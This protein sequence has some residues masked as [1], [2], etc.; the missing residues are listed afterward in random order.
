MDETIELIQVEGKCNWIRQNQPEIWEA[1]HKYLQISGFLN[2][3][4]TAVF[5]D[6]TA[7]Q[8]GH[9]PFNYKK[10]RWAKKLELPSLIFPIEAE[11]LPDIVEP[12]EQLGK[13]TADAAAATGLAEDIPVIACGVT[14]SPGS[15]LYAIFNPM[16]NVP[17]PAEAFDHPFICPVA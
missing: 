1:T 2:F 13:I 10:I 7:S 3:R 11:K 9:I 5:A 4:L 15:C 14:P 16:T 12:G 8:I 6:S 17:L